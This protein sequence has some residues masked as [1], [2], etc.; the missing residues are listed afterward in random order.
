ME[1]EELLSLTQASAL[2]G[3]SR[4]QLRLLAKQGKLR[5]IKVGSAWVTT[6]KAVAD[7]MAD[8]E[9]RSKDPRKNK[10]R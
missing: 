4:S 10:R 7:Y 3:L 2:F 6:R 9:L 5:A 8:P 1:G